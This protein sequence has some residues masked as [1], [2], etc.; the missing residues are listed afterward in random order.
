MFGQ[1][2]PRSFL[3]LVGLYAVLTIGI[4]GCGSEDDDN[5]K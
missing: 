3:W 5:E 2:I 1:A 4:T